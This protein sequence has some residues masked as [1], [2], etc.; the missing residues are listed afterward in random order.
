MI[1]DSGNCAGSHVGREVQLEAGDAVLC[2][3]SEVL[4]GYS[5]GRRVML[6]VPNKA[7][8][9]ALTDLGAKISR[10]IPR[11]TEGLQLLRQYLRVMQDAES[12]AKPA[13]QRLAVAHIHDLLAMT[14]GATRD[15]AQAAEAGGGRAARLRGIKE[16]VARNLGHGD[17]SLA[18]MAARHRI[19]P[20]T[21]QKLF[22]GEGTTFS[23][24]VLDQRL[25]HAHRL[26]GDPRYTA[27]K[28]ASLAFAAGFGDLSHFYRAFRRRYGV[29][30]TDVR[31]RNSTGQATG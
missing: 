27:E 9:P 11:Q 1:V 24:Y 20:R 5:F 2:M 17:V 14:L 21:I 22:E 15:A 29:L 28:I 13:F 18:A 10:R 7:I 26:L 16:D 12:L 23:E 31:A 25:A 4:S 6:R 30:P 19:S 8:A 3:N